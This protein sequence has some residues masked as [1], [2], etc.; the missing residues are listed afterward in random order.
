MADMYLNLVPI[1]LLY[2]ATPRDRQFRLIRL[3]GFI[4]YMGTRT[5]RKL[6]IN[7]TQIES[8]HSP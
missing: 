1:H 4:I 8:P 5:G 3:S 6:P 7:Q 2:Y